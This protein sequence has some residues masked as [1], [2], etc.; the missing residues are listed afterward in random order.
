MRLKRRQ[1]TGSRGSNT[2]G[3]IDATTTSEQ[4]R[5]LNGTQLVE[6]DCAIVMN[7]WWQAVAECCCEPCPRLE[8]EDVEARGEAH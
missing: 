2:G 8:I 4:Q 6:N 3:T 5:P 1:A 7:A